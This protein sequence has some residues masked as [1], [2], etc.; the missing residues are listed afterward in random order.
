[1]LQDKLNDLHLEKSEMDMH[2][3]GKT[4]ESAR[5]KQLQDEV[6][7]VQKDMENKV[8]PL[9][10]GRFRTPLDPVLAHSYFT[11]GNCST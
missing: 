9:A 10:V 1:M 11:G 7:K 5:I 4:A 6:L 2:C 3:S 8:W